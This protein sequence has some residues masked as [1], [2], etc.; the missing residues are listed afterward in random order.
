[1]CVCVYVYVRG[2]VCVCNIG[3]YLIISDCVNPTALITF[4]FQCVILYI[5]IK[6]CHIVINCLKKCNVLYLFLSFVV[7]F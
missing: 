5:C 6:L 2:C 1:M 4:I 7:H 3:L